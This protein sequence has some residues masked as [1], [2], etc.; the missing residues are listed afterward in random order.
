MKGTIQ[1]ASSHTGELTSNLFPM[2][3]NDEV[4]GQW[5]S[6]DWTIVYHTITL[7]MEDLRFVRNLLQQNNFYECLVLCF[8]PQIW[9]ESEPVQ[10]TLFWARY[11][12]C[13]FKNQWKSAASRR[14]KISTIAYFNNMFLMEKILMAQ[15]TLIFLMKYQ[16]FVI[17]IKQSILQQI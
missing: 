16:R 2:R 6:K 9:V 17:N 5:T 15:Y 10:I 14:L 8:I 1:C 13:I 11:R 3:K 12:L 4:T 7:K